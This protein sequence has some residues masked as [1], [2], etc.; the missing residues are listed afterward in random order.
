MS[1]RGTWN[2]IIS[3]PTICSIDPVHSVVC[4]NTIQLD[5]P[6]YHIF[7]CGGKLRPSPSPADGQ[8]GSSQQRSLDDPVSAVY[9]SSSK[10]FQYRTATYTTL[11]RAALKLQGRQLS[12]MFD[13]IIFP[14]AL[15]AV[16]SSI[17][18]VSEGLH[19]RFSTKLRRN[20]PS[21][22][23]RHKIDSRFHI[24]QFEYCCTQHV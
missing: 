7:W 15:D 18:E 9:C 19:G 3:L 22:G 21:R 1:R 16:A 17:G 8:Q 2:R 11:L 23:R 6:S 20:G 24:R 13:V 4:F 10:Y 5:H 14:P 12:S